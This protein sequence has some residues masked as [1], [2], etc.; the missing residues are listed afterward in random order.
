[1]FDYAAERGKPERLEKMKPVLDRIPP[2]W[3]DYLPEIGWD[4]LLLELD[5]KLAAIDPGYV[6]YQ[7]KQ[8][9]G[10]LRYYTAHSEDFEGDQ[11]TFS[12]LIAEAESRS[13]TVCEICGGAAT[14][15]SGSWIMVLCDDHA[16]KQ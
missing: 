16:N 7:A 6:V 4:D 2:M 5:A 9:F 12:F 8:K 10:G 15:R 14:R 1:M 13:A 11:T 3:G